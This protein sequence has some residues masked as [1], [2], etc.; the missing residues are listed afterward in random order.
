[1]PLFRCF[2]LLFSVCLLLPVNTLAQ[3]N[4]DQRS[5]IITAASVQ[6]FRQISS[7]ILSAHKHQPR[8]VGS[9]EQWHLFLK[10]EARNGSGGK[11]F[12]TIFGYR[13]KRADSPLENSWELVLPSIGIDPENCPLISR[14][15][16]DK[17][18]L[19]LPPG[20]DLKDRCLQKP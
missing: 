10:K 8:Y 6:E 14:F 1:M 11:H 3:S 9:T 12:S 17:R 19:F 20:S 2:S 13:I 5:L 4:T 7:R 15:S 18:S 16:A